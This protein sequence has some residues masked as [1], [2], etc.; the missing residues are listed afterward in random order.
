MKKRS[1]TKEQFK[2]RVS[3]QQEKD[4]PGVQQEGAYW[5]LGSNATQAGSLHCDL[6]R[7]RAIDLA[8]HDAIGVYP[9]TG[10]WKTHPGQKR[11]NDKGRYALVVSISAPGHNVDMHAEISAIVAAKIAS[12]VTS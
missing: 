10:W 6:W 9:V 4:T 1:D 7:G 8:L 5:L 12:M 3:G 11:F 2:R